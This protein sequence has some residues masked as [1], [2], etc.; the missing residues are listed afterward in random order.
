MLAKR[1]LEGMRREAGVCFASILAGTPLNRAPL[2]GIGDAMSGLRWLDGY[3]GQSVDEL[4]AFAS[5]Y[6]VDSIVSAIDQALQQTAERIGLSQL[7]EVELTIVVVE[8][9]DREVNNGGYHQFFLNTPEYAPFV[10]AALQR[11]RCPKTSDISASAISL[12]GLGQQFATNQVQ[13]ALDKDIGGH[14]IDVLS[15][16]C[17]QLYYDSGE[18]IADRLFAFVRTHCSSI[19]LQMYDAR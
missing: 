10:V 9:L 3:S 15:D 4:I 14:L 13:R 16:Q 18:P 8:A 19:R 1:R 2:A 7:N 5:Q 6:R 12:L 11:I 17:D